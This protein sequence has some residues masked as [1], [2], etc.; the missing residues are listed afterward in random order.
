MVKVTICICTALYGYATTSC[1]QFVLLAIYRPSSQAVSATFYNDL[2][3][4]F[5]WLATYSC[6]VV[7]CGDSSIHVDDPNAVDSVSSG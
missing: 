1:N 4:V 3:T 7:I 5:E 2:S 6:P